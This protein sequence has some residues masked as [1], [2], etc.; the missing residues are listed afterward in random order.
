MIKKLVCILLGCTVALLLIS[1]TVFI[2]TNHDSSDVAVENHG[3]EPTIDPELEK[4]TNGKTIKLDDYYNG[5]TSITVV[6]GNTGESKIL[7]DKE[8]I[9]KIISLL[10]GE[11]YEVETENY[12]GWSYRLAFNKSDEEVFGIVPNG[13]S[14]EVQLTDDNVCFASSNFDY[15]AYNKLIKEIFDNH[16]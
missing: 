14:I 10:H 2:A 9:N 15:K 16:S 1:G 7:D 13:H 11:M 8:T 3:A 6:S 4:V 12:E 5:I